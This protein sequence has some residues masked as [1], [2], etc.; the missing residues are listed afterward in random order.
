MRC[1]GRLRRVCAE[2]A[3]AGHSGLLGSRGRDG[4]L[5]ARGGVG[6]H[7]AGA[8]WRA[9]S[10]SDGD[11]MS[12]SEAPQKMIAQPATLRR[13][14][15]SPRSARAKRRL[16]TSS[17]VK[18]PPRSDSGPNSSAAVYRPFPA[19][20]ALR[21]ARGHTVMLALEGDRAGRAKVAMRCACGAPRGGAAAARLTHAN[22]YSP[23]DDGAPL[24]AAQWHP[25]SSVRQRV[26]LEHHREGN[27]DG[28]A[29][30][31]AN[32]NEQ[33]HEAG[34][35]L[36]TSAKPREQS[37]DVSRIGEVGILLATRTTTAYYYLSTGEHLP[38]ENHGLRFDH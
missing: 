7:A 33:R 24:H 11:P 6:R 30:C 37:T 32:A 28:A 22:P 5:P 8:R 36:G 23:Q 18:T 29:H 26:T 2:A 21:A 38:Y 15:T 19:A 1:R 25:R 16:K 20:S 9:H 35:S 14:R 27:D 12:V 4:A 13:V 31:E 34:R 3:C 10:V 17:V